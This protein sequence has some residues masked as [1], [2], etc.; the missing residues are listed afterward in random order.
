M[1]SSTRAGKASANGMN[2]SGSP[3]RMGIFGS[4][5]RGEQSVDSDID[6][7][8]EYTETPDLLE[9]VNMENRISELLH[10]KVDLIPR[11]CLRPELTGRILAELV[12]V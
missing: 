7:L 4:C 3:L 8:V 9:I 1:F 10:E 2:E 6:I 12:P 5:A 11:E